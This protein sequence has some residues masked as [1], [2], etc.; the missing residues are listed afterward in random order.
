MEMTKKD[1]IRYQELMDRKGK[2][3]EYQ[4]KLQ[5]RRRGSRTYES[6][7]AVTKNIQKIDRDI[8]ELTK[9][10]REL[11]RKYNIEKDPPTTNSI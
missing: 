2:L 4:R 3:I 1:D 6:Y 10:I 11:R 5:D 9:A 7:M 8:Q